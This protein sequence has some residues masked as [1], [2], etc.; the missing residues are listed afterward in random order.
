MPTTQN[1]DDT[2]R[3][4]SKL[5]Q[6]ASSR[7]LGLL[8]AVGIAVCCGLPL[9]IGA[10]ALAAAGGVLGSPAVIAA[11]V[12]LAVGT[13]VWFARRRRAGHAACC[14]PQTARPAGDGH[15]LGAGHD[16]R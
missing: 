11:G 7:D 10:G 12:A 16:E 3:R 15:R 6:P 13:V 14:P 2:D 9:L 8:A 4:G 5:F 1:R